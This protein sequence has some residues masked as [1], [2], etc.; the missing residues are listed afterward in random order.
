[1]EDAV[2][3]NGLTGV[4]GTGG[5][6]GA[7]TGGVEMLHGTVIERERSLVED[8]GGDGDCSEG[9]DEGHRSFAR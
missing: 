7:E 5:I 3:E 8:N 4:F 9:A 1:M 2:L 6:E